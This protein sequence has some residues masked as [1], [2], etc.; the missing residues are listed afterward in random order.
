VAFF[1]KSGAHEI[2]GAARLLRLEKKNEPGQMAYCVKIEI[3]DAGALGQTMSDIRSW[4]DDHNIEAVG[5][6]YETA[7]SG[8]LVIALCFATAKEAL[9]FGDSRTA[10]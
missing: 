8:A 9:L 7:E 6:S 1:G 10:G 2:R 5:F 3:V 4:L